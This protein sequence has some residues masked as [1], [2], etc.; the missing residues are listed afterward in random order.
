M[1]RFGSAQHPSWT[2]QTIEEEVLASVIG[3]PTSWIQIILTANYVERPSLSTLKFHFIFFLRV[4]ILVSMITPLSVLSF[5]SPSKQGAILCGS[6][7]LSTKFDI[8]YLKPLAISAV[9]LN[10]DKVVNGEISDGRGMVSPKL[11]Y[12]QNIDT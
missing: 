2:L 5:P 3:I 9:S 7:F 6:L 1:E 12:H 10:K 11:V 8:N 4:A